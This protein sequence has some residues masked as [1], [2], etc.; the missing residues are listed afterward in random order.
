MRDKLA[1]VGSFILEWYFM[2]ENTIAYFLTFHFFANTKLYS[3]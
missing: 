2:M 3:Q 1:F